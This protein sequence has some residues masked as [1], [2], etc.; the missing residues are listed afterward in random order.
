VGSLEAPYPALDSRFC[1]TLKTVMSA[2]PPNHAWKAAPA[3]LGDIKPA[4]PP[5]GDDE[6]HAA[7]YVHASEIGCDLR[8][9]GLA[10]LF[11]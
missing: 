5:Q 1:K 7:I 4:G 8:R 11:G 9:I 3:A 2:L 6:S 10:L